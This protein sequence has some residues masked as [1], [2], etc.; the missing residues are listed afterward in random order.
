MGDTVLG[1][2]RDGRTISEM[3]LWGID[4]VSFWWYSSLRDVGEKI[5]LT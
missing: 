3:D 4:G 2:S 5:V 1:R